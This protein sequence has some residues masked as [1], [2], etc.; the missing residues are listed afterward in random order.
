[1]TLEAERFGSRSGIAVTVRNDGVP[2][3]LALAPQSEVAVFR[4]LQE[5]L[6]NAGR[7]SR[8]H[9]VDV[10]LRAG[11]GELWLSISDDGAGF[12]VEE[13]NASRAGRF[14]IVG[15]YE[16]ARL[17][18]AELEVS[19]GPEGGTRVSLRVPLEPQQTAASA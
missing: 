8:A 14:G 5:A 15:M 3:D 16:R 19:S 18:G 7:H 2:R 10:E 6:A 13:E 17:I 12:N 9:T 1:V 11:G 4:I